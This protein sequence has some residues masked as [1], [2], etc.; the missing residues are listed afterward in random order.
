M[1]T[2]IFNESL[3]QYLLDIQKESKDQQFE[4]IANNAVCTFCDNKPFILNGHLLACPVCKVIIQP[5]QK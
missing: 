2:D 5:Q 4:Q 3:F 1:P